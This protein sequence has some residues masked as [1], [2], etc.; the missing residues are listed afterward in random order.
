MIE[1]A[2]QMST[3]LRCLAATC[4]FESV[5]KLVSSPLNKINVKKFASKAQEAYQYIHTGPRCK[6]LQD[7]LLKL[8]NLNK[9]A[10]Q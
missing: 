5:T 10:F 6:M 1:I 3:P 7:F 8:L 2:I 4:G 9:N